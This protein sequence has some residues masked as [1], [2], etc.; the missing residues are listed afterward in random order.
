MKKICFLTFLLCVMATFTAS[1]QYIG[2]AGQ[3]DRKG[4]NLYASDG[5]KIDNAT[6]LQ[7]MSEKT[8]YEYYRPGK[9]LFTSGIVLSAT[10]AGIIVGSV[11]FDL[12]NASLHPVDPYKV[13]YVPVV[14]LIGGIAGGAMLLVSVPLYA[15]GAVKL[16]K[17]AEKCGPQGL[18]YSP[19]LS[20]VSRTGGL[21]LVIDF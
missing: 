9:S 7:Y 10:G 6:A 14:S 4:G 2:N 3:V 11:A 16:N 19:E 5:T 21:G 12:I 1:A 13:V 8:Y 17:A 18:S 15:V 20:F